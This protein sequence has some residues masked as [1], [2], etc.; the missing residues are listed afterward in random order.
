MEQQSAAS[1]H[2]GG[3][4]QAP[5]DLWRKEVHAHIAGY[6]SRR[7]RRLAGAFSMRFPF[8]PLE[9]EARASGAETGAGE[10]VDFDALTNCRQAPI[11]IAT[12]HTAA[13]E[14]ASLESADAAVQTTSEPSPPTSETSVAVSDA[15]AETEPAPVPR[16]R[17]RRKIIAFPR[18]VAP[19]ALDPPAD[20]IDQERPRILDVT[21][22]FG[23]HS[24]TP[25]LDGL[26]FPSPAPQSTAAPAEH[27]ELPFRAVKISLRLYAGLID[28]ALVGAAAA[29][30]GAVTYKLLPKLA[31]G[32]PVLLTSAALVVL[33]WAVYQ[34]LFVVYAGRTAGM[35]AAGIRL[36]TFHGGAPGW[37][38]RHSRVISLYF[39]AASLTMGLLW[40]LV[41]VDALCWHD[42]LSQTY[43]TTAVGD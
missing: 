2:P 36:S 41:D 9:T 43:P 24:T 6:R 28:C 33:L 21:E 29:V 18:P 10:A 40:A 7:G 37:R 1:Q 26:Q 19:Y 25:L 38:Q 31:L 30:L 13:A 5:N 32:K 3:P 12:E 39:S 27:V 11:P 20:P 4:A 8:P 22:E 17:A 34:Y 14:G 16:A 42:R 15:E 35:R 23:I